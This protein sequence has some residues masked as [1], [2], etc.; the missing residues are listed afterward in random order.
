MTKLNNHRLLHLEKGQKHV[1]RKSKK[2]RTLCS[3]ALGTVITTAI[4]LGGSLVQ[5]DEV[6]NTES[7]Q[8]TTL[9]ENPATNLVEA[10]PS[11]TPAHQ[12]AETSTEQVSGEILITIDHSSLDQAVTEAESQGVNVVEDAAVDL[13]TTQTSNEMCSGIALRDRK[14]LAFECRF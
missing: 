5:A 3:V 11:E 12:I 2:Y 13:G 10:Q 1:F 9:T 8:S 4:A 6:L 14:F 7:S